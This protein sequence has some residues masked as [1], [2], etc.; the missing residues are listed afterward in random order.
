MLAWVDE[1]SSEARLA[2]LIDLSRLPAHIAVG[3]ARGRG[4]NAVCLFCRKLEASS[5][6]SDGSDG[7]TETISSA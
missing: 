5:C 7:L 4:P 1:G 6:R 3:P 2:R